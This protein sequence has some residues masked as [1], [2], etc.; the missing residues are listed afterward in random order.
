M[1]RRVLATLLA[2]LLMWSAVAGHEAATRLAEASADRV[3]LVLPDD[4]DD[5]S[6]EDHHLDDVPAQS[7]AENPLDLPAL[8]VSAPIR[9]LREPARTR[10][11][12]RLRGEHPPPTP[13]R[14][15]RPPRSA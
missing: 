10:A 2:A 15:L 4:L 6:V 7:Q 1:L 8:P 14:L 12:A 11:E 9:F 13:E 3:V 5:G